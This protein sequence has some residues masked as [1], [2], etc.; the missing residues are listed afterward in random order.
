M[1]ESEHRL[2]G[3]V[4]AEL[5]DTWGLCHC[6][7]GTTRWWLTCIVFESANSKTYLQGWY[8]YVEAERRKG[9]RFV[10]NLKIRSY[11]TTQIAL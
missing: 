2:E 1:R 11:E 3:E 5:G 9:H 7:D 8:Q 4:G 6:L 10:G